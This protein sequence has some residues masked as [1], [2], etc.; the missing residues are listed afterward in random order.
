[1]TGSLYIIPFNNQ[2]QVL[3]VALHP[4]IIDYF[5]IPAHLKL[6]YSWHN[7]HTLSPWLE[8]NLEWCQSRMLMRTLGHSRCFFRFMCGLLVFFHLHFP[9]CLIQHWILNQTNIFILHPT[10]WDINRSCCGK[11]NVAT[12]YVCI[13]SVFFIWTEVRVLSDHIVRVD[14]SKKS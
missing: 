10:P 2:L 3:T 13:R 1:M 5:P 7:T 8:P 9:W 14:L 12:A 4:W 6:Y 11:V